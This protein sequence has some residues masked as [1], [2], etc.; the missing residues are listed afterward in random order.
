MKI[1]EKLHSALLDLK[2]IL[3]KIIAALENEEASPDKL[4][5]LYLNKQTT[6][7]RL[8]QIEEEFPEKIEEIPDEKIN[9]IQDLYRQIKKMDSK[10]LQKINSGI[11]AFAN[12]IRKVDKELEARDIYATD[13]VQ[14]NTLFIKRKLEG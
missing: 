1:I 13:E 6:I 2:N 10:A 3:S 4:Q 12:N 9:E 11:K 5:A 14:D 7:N 8:N